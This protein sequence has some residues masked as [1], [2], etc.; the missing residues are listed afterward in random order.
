MSKS[1][2]GFASDWLHSATAILLFLF[3]AAYFIKELVTRPMSCFPPVDWEKL[4]NAE[5][6]V[7][8]C[9]NRGL[10]YV[11]PLG[12]PIPSEEVM[13]ARQVSFYKIAMWVAL[14]QAILCT[15]PELVWGKVCRQRSKCLYGDP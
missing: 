4:P 5:L 14:G 2:A 12:Q 15:V 9:Y 3:A 7:S 13:R 11:H 6:V 1:V 8:T 10:L